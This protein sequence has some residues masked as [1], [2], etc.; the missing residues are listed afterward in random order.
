MNRALVWGREE[1]H[2]LSPPGD[3]IKLREV[4]KALTTKHGGKLSCGTG[5]DLWYS[6]N[7]RDT[8]ARGGGVA[9]PLPCKGCR[10]KV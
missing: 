8:R 10:G 2:L 1:G 5:N 6:N 7:V 4:P 3:T 9:T